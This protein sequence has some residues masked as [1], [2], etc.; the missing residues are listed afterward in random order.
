MF[1]SIENPNGALL[2]MECDI[3]T[4][5]RLE[6]TNKFLIVLHFPSRIERFAQ[7]D[8]EITIGFES[9]TDDPQ[10]HVTVPCLY[11]VRRIFPS[12]RV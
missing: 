3:A 8:A 12:Q 5:R 10:C 11:Q 2:E 6:Y 7:S 9:A 4:M 1:V